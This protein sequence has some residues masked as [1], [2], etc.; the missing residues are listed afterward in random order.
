MG[1]HDLKV[2][3]NAFADQAMGRKLHLHTLAAF[4]ALGLALPGLALAEETI[5]ILFRHAE[6]TTESEDP[7][8][9]DEG[10]N[11]ALAIGSFLQQAGV[12]RIFSSDYK[13]TRETVEPVSEDMGIEIEIY[14]PRDLGDFAKALRDMSG[15]IAISGH[16]N[17]TPELAALV[18]GQPTEPMPE[19]EYDRLYTIIRSRGGETIVNV[20]Q[21]EQLAR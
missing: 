19:T 17:T 21:Q 3:M 1:S 4:L 10:K 18:S 7:G 8:L 9:S 15:V 14:D 20:S 2:Q 11:R 6:K 12:T 16:S 5:Y 13:R